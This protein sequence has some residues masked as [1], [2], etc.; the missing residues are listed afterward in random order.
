MRQLGQ[1]VKRPGRIT[2]KLPTRPGSTDPPDTLRK[3]TQIG[4]HVPTTI[5]TNSRRH[6]AQNL[7]PRR[8]SHRH[9]LT[10]LQP[11]QRHTQRRTHQI[12]MRTHTFKPRHRNTLLDNEIKTHRNTPLHK[13]DTRR[14]ILA[15]LSVTQPPTSREHEAS[16]LDLHTSEKPP[17]CREPLAGA[18]RGCVTGRTKAET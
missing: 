13:R 14:D 12:T 2:S 16:S 10:V 15:A 6:I 1:L 18:D 9:A 5:N 4:H 17:A 7:P 8:T 3:H 11:K